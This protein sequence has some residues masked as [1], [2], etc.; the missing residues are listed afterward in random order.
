MIF[1][2]M[3]MKNEASRYLEKC[4]E[5]NRPFVDELF[6]YDDCSTD[7]SVEIAKGYATVVRQDGDV[8]FMEHEGKFR[9]QAWRAFESEMNPI[10]GDW[11][12]SFDADEMLTTRRSSSP[13]DVRAELDKVVDTSGLSVSIEIPFLEMFQVDQAGIHS[14]RIDGFWGTIKAQRFFAY[15]EGGFFSPKAMGCGSAPTY[16][17]TG[18]CRGTSRDLLFLHYG[19]ALFDDRTS[20]YD[21]YSSLVESGHNP[22]H[23]ESILQHPTLSRWYGPHPDLSQ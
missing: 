23:I 7:S 17:S 21:R 2:L 20:R 3:V 15:K 18:P 14:Y 9:E 6:V 4:L 8:G 19:Y 11:V 13:G 22:R 16:V 12:L 5:W 10:N 1:G